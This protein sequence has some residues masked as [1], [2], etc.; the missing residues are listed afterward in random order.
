[1]N[2]GKPLYHCKQVYGLRT[3]ICVAHFPSQN[4]SSQTALSY[5]IGEEFRL[6][7]GCI[8]ATLPTQARFKIPRPKAP[9][10]LFLKLS[11]FILFT[12]GIR[13]IPKL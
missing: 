8:G 9:H 5:G 11:E 12:L 6:Q 4:T 1:M 10:R 3:C 7:P 13:L 2:Q